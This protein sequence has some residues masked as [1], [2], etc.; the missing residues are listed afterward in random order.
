M[1]L[2]SGKRIIS[3]WFPELVCSGIKQIIEKLRQKQPASL[4]YDNSQEVARQAFCCPRARC[5]DDYRAP[6]SRSK[7]T[8]SKRL[9]NS[10][11]PEKKTDK[12]SFSQAFGWNIP[13]GIPQCVYDRDCKRGQQKNKDRDHKAP[14]P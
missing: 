12:H 5:P 13:V 8:V 11:W 9:S 14:P 2:R 6:S 3:S 4:H 10:T 7:P 1:A